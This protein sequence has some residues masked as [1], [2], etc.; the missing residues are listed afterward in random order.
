MEGPLFSLTRFAALGVLLP[1][2]SGCA[3]S[4]LGPTYTPGLVNHWASRSAPVLTAVPPAIGL[5]THI[6]VMTNGKPT[7]RLSSVNDRLFYRRYFERQIKYFPILSRARYDLPNTPYRL[8]IEGVWN[9]G[10][11]GEHERF[12]ELHGVLYRGDTEL[13]RYDARGSYKVELHLI[14]MPDR[15]P[16]H[17]GAIGQR[18]PPIWDDSVR[19]LLL[20]VERDANELFQEEW[21][22]VPSTKGTGN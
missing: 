12:L 17:L 13:R 14:G 5:E 1:L 15:Y 16:I 7:S 10:S 3:G 4:L 22:T 2:L 9:F 20:Q 11:L 21:Q 18:L 6:S 19:D 8:H